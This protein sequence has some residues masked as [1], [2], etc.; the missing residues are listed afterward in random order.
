MPTKVHSKQLGPVTLT[1][2]TLILAA[3]CGAAPDRSSAIASKIGPAATCSATDYEITLRIDNSKERIYSCTNGA[4]STD[5]YV[6]DGGLVQKDTETV[7]LL[8]T[9]VVGSAKPDCIS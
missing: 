7:R 2:T 6:E 5:C 1:L 3:G 8:W 9:N 4:G